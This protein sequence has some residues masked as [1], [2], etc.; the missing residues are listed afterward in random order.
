[1]Y[2][3]NYQCFTFPL[4]LLLVLVLLIYARSMNFFL[5]NT[6]RQISTDETSFPPES[7][8]FNMLNKMMHFPPVPFPFSPVN[9]DPLGI[10]ARYLPESSKIHHISALLETCPYLHDAFSLIFHIQHLCYGLYFLPGSNFAPFE[11]VKLPVSNSAD[12]FTLTAIW[13]II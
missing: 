9:P 10:L 7:C 13:S 11:E 5:L 12:L 8:T 6:L 3:S 2:V 4:T 1:M